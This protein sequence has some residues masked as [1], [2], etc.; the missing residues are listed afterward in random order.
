MYMHY[1]EIRG[2]KEKIEIICNLFIKILP[3]FIDIHECVC[4]HTQTHTHIIYKTGLILF[5]LF[6]NLLFPLNNIL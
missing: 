5:I 6:C 4:T 3:N 1:R 2:E